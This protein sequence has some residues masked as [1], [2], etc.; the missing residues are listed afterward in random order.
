MKLLSIHAK[1]SPI[2]RVDNFEN[3]SNKYA[4]MTVHNP[5]QRDTA[6]NLNQRIRLVQ[7]DLPERGSRFC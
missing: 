5:G 2:N 6:F 3:N 1:K 7:G 4:A